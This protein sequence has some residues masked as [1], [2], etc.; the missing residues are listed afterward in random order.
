MAPNVVAPHGFEPH[1]FPGKGN[2]SQ[3]T[4]APMPVSP[5]CHREDSVPLRLSDSR[6]VPT[7]NGVAKPD[8]P[9]AWSSSI[10]RRGIGVA[11]QESN[12]P[13]RVH[14]WIQADNSTLVLASPVVATPG[15]GRSQST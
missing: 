1:F 12:V 9:S 8:L 4:T 5:G 3:N 10:P 2:V 13:T 14:T 7:A 15:Y 6:R 11:D